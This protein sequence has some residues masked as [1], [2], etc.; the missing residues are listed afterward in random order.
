[1]LKVNYGYWSFVKSS[2][3]KIARDA[4]K[5]A[6]WIVPI[7]AIIN[8][9]FL[10][11][12]GLGEYVARFLLISIGYGAI[13]FIAA[14]GF[15]AVR[16]NLME[17]GLRASLTQKVAKAAETFLG[18]DNSVK[19]AD[20]ELFA[21]AHAELGT[22]QLK[23]GLWAKA[24][25]L[26]NADEKKQQVQYIKLRVREMH[27]DQLRDR[28][29]GEIWAAAEKLQRERIEAEEKERRR[30]ESIAKQAAEEEAVRQERLRQQSEYWNPGRSAVAI[31]MIVA[32][33]A[34]LI[35]I[36]GGPIGP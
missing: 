11:K 36:S 17:P 18:D 21:A 9:N 8:L 13:F 23:S 30:C 4:A 19:D 20:S 16:K 14:W 12:F 24:L 3:S 31:L 35:F 1:M 25:V 29:E 26:A 5:W 34:F 6:L 7:S 22:D 27:E 15:I 32:L 33:L 10:N 2:S 28:K